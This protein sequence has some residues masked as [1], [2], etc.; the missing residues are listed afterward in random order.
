MKAHHFPRLAAV[1]LLASGTAAPAG[2]NPVVKVPVVFVP[3]V[4]LA[5]GGRSDAPLGGA[6]SG[7]VS[8]AAGAVPVSVGPAAVTAAATATATGAMAAGAAQAQQDA[9]A[10]AA[11]AAA[12]ITQVVELCRGLPN[13]SYAVDCMAAGLADVAAAVPQG[14]DEAALRATLEEAARGLRALARQNQDPALPRVTVRRGELAL[15]RPLTAVVPS[16]A[17]A[18]A[19][20]AIVAEAQTVLLRSAPADAVPEYNRISAA[21]DSSRVLLRSS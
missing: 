20:D 14:G 11:R 17:V 13:P 21:L 9:A 12:Q 5:P 3:P 16:P 19:A 6:A 1:A 18:A 2:N 7:A 8:G 15:S 4:M 10:A